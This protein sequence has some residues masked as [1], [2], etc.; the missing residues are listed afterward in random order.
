M[1]TCEI[2]IE[3]PE[4]VADALAQKI[5]LEDQPE[6]IVH[7]LRNSLIMRLTPEKLAERDRLIEEA[8][9]IIETNPVSDEEEDAWLAEM[10]ARTPHARTEE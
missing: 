7:A 2:T 1:A 4:E 5:A 6:F 3:I 9:D 10:W 8:C